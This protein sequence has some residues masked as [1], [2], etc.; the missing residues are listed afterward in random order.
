[1]IPKLCSAYGVTA[2]ETLIIKHKIKGRS[3]GGKPIIRAADVLNEVRCMFLPSRVSSMKQREIKLYYCTKVKKKLVLFSR[4]GHETIFVRLPENF[5]D[6][7]LQG[8]D[9]PLPSCKNL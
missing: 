3:I 1:M 9:L 2:S 7:H 4:N 8:K 6:C 5:F